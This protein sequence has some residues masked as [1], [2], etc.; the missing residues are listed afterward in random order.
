MIIPEKLR[1]IHFAH[2]SG[3]LSLSLHLTQGKTLGSHNSSSRRR[4]CVGCKSSIMVIAKA[5]RATI[6]A[7]IIGKERNVDVFVFLLDPCAFTCNKQGLEN[8]QAKST[9][10]GNFMSV[11]LLK[12]LKL[13]SFGASLVLSTIVIPVIFEHHT[14]K[15]GRCV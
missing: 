3:W 14:Y 11:F 10:N 15:K 8:K 6:V 7:T 9:R 2:S 13:A 1:G 5:K 12:S 4:R